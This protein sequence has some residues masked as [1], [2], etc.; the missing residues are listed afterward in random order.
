MSSRLK[1][2]GDALQVP[3]T[4]FRSSSHTRKLS[5]S[6]PESSTEDMDHRRINPLG[7]H[8]VYEPETI[9]S[10]DIIFVHGLGGTS[11]ATWAWNRDTNFFWPGKWLPKEPGICTARILSFGYDADFKSTQAGVVSSVSDFAKDLLFSMKF[12]RNEESGTLGIGEVVSSNVWNT[13]RP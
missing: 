5:L 4:S 10:V 11:Q 2:V 7:L 3:N 13:T 9:P 12:G 6:P 1:S 8:A